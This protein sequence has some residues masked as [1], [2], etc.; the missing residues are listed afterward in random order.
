MDAV[1]SAYLY[2]RAL[3]L[4]HFQDELELEL[5]GVGFGFVVGHVLPSLFGE[6]I[7]SP[8]AETLAL[9]VVRT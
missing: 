2:L 7:A 9:G 6:K 3:S 1:G 5:W 4:K 8:G